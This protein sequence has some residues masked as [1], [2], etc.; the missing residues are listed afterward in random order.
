MSDPKHKV[1]TPDEILALDAAGMRKYNKDLMRQFKNPDAPKV[2]QH[3]RSFQDL[4][5]FAQEDA[6][7]LS[8]A[9]QASRKAGDG[10]DFNDFHSFPEAV[11]VATSGWPEGTKRIKKVAATL[12]DKVLA[13]IKVQDFTTDDEGVFLDT[14][15]YLDNDPDCL[16]KLEDT[17][18]EQHG[19][20]N[21]RIFMNCCVSGKVNHKVLAMRGAAVVALV[22]GLT[23]AGKQV[24][25]TVGANTANALEVTFVAK[26]LDEPLQMDQLAFS[27]ASA[28]MFRRFCFASWERVDDAALLRKVGIRASGGYGRVANCHHVHDFDV[29]LTTLSGYG[30]ADEFASVENAEAWVMDKLRM[31]GVQMEFD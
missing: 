22:E 31:L 27:V 6:P 12:T 24:E 18:L 8:K 20:N 28:D 25:L 19:A 5:R 16:L 17:E 30:N 10:G 21:I 2:H 3:F 23:L 29:I 14:E 7:H 13:T 4:V 26:P 9:E 11:K 1:L 15:R